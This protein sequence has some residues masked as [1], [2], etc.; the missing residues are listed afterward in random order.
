MAAPSFRYPADT[1]SAATAFMEWR[2]R[3]ARAQKPGGRAPPPQYSKRCCGSDISLYECPTCNCPF[4]M[5]LASVALDNN[6][7]VVVWEATF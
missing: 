7:V 1:A 4:G 6:T 5:S 2:G 3:R